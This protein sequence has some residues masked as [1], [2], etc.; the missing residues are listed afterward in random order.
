MFTKG[1]GQEMLRAALFSIPTQGKPAKGSPTE[2]H[3]VLHSHREIICSNYKLQML[4]IIWMNLRNMMLSKISQIL[5]SMAWFHLYKVPN[6]AG[7]TY[8][9]EVRKWLSLVKKWL[10]GAQRSFWSFFFLIR[11]LDTKAGL[12]WLNSLHCIHM[13]SRVLSILTYGN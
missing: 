11:V 12:C 2:K 7:L 13:I 9:I 10:G 3:I 6:Q 5:K 1:Q 4:I 8:V